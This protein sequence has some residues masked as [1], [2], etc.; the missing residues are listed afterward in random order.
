GRWLFRQIADRRS[1]DDSQ[2]L[3]LD[4]TLPDPTPKLPVWLLNVPQGTVGWNRGDY[5]AEK[6][7][8]AWVLFEH[9]WRPLDKKKDEMIAELPKPSPA[10]PPPKPAT[11]T[12]APTTT[13]ESL[14]PPILLD[15][16]GNRWF[17]GKEKLID[18]DP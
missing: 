13:Q 7:G 3:L 18:I 17:D 2:T 5:P 12:S 14:G 16:D 4:P 1:T 10:P 9:G 6:S 8:D 11:T 15:R